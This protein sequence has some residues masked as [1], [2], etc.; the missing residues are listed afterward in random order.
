MK[1]PCSARVSNAEH[2]QMSREA[3]LSPNNYW[4]EATV[5]PV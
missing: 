2:G 1:C 3:F 4:A 5:L